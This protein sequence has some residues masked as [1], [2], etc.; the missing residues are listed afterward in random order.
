MDLLLRIAGSLVGLLMV[1]AFLRSMLQVALINSQRG[2]WLARRVG[3]LV[4]TTIARRALRR[5]SY[6]QIQDKLAWILPT[7]I[8]LLIAAWFALVQ[9]GFSLLIWSSQAEH[10]LLQ[11][12][13]ASGSA[14]S[15]LGFLTPPDVAGQL[16][17]IPEGAMGLGIVV[18]LFTFIPGYQT[19]IQARQAKVAWLYART[20]P[21]AAGFAL[22]EWF[23]LSRKLGD[24][25]EVWEDWEGWFRHLIETH[26][27][28]PVLA[29]VPTVHRGQT[30][31]IAAVAILD[32]ASF[33]ISALDAKGLPSAGLCHTT[34]VR[35]LRLMAAELA[36]RRVASAAPPTGPC[37]NRAAF[38]VCC[39][40]LASLS[41]PIK[42]DRDECWR[43]FTE[44]RREYEVSL[45][46]LA[47]S[48]LVPMDNLPT[49]LL[50]LS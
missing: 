30:W 2:D 38:D 43:R 22:V 11:A 7:Y 31:L 16:L 12:V 50:D 21:E 10:S 4:Y 39:D 6:D 27:L 42:G 29:F 33:C 41:S 34:G 37:L 35:A 47:T 8:L 40:R 23:Q 1:L 9:T 5:H 20:G 17:A 3:W 24:M 14:L 28:A 46:G 48:L 36:D 19:A 25:T 49:L 44:L 13:I 26:R 18:F 45:P 32:A 15:T